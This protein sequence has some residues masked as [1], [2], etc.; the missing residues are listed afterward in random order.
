MKTIQTMKTNAR[1]P[2]V[3][4]LIIIIS[5]LFSELFVRFGIIV[6]GDSPI[7]IVIDQYRS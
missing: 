2:S 1:T 7:A 4:Y 5:G 6:P 3:M